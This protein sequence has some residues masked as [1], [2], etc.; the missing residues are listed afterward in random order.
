MGNPILSDD[1]VGVRLATDLSEK[2][3]PR[4]DLDVVNECAVGGLNLLDVVAGYDRVIVVD[5][6]KTNGGVPGTWYRFDACSL[7][8][9]MNLRN[10]HDTNFATALELGRHA[11]MHL[12][13]DEENHI[14]AIE[15]L[16]NS[17]FS[18]RITAELEA[19]YPQLLAE[20][21]PEVEALVGPPEAAT[22]E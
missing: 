17:T 9:T 16:D 8:E 13:A 18:E 20:I 1:A 6:I 11:G 3:G 12:P 19:V 2:L 14:F 21:L 4:C 5:S 10:V 15:I 22:P 7:R